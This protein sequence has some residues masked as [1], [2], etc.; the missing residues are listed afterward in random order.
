MAARQP[1]LLIVRDKSIA[2]CVMKRSRFLSQEALIPEKL[3][4]RYSSAICE[5]ESFNLVFT[6]LSAAIEA[7]EAASE[8]MAQNHLPKFNILAT[9]LK[10]GVPKQTKGSNTFKC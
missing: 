8:E 2:F 9:V 4:V 3:S 10:W 1:A 6:S 5:T 7:W